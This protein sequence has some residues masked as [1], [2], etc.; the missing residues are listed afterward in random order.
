MNCCLQFNNNIIILLLASELHSI[1]DIVGGSM[2]T[3]YT[4]NMDGVFA[5][6]AN[7]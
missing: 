7:G 5:L 1:I 2:F 6:Y 3:V 4:I